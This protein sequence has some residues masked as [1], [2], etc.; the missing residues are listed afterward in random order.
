V[1]E[2]VFLNGS[3]VGG[4]TTGMECVD[5]GA[6]GWRDAGAM[7]AREEL[8]LFPD[9]ATKRSEATAVRTV[10]TSRDPQRQRLCRRARAIAGAGW[11]QV[12]NTGP[13][14][15]GL[16]LCHWRTPHGREL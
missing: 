8:C 11:I 4:G 7:L 5:D 1:L 6:R 12:D 10:R 13:G 16:Q 2:I 14:R 9:A 3:G 15:G